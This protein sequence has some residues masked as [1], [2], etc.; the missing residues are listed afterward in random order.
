[1]KRLIACP[2]LLAHPP[3]KCRQQHRLFA[4]LTHRLD[5]GPGNNAGVAQMSQEQLC[6]EYLGK[7]LRTS[8]LSAS[9]PHLMI[10]KGVD[11]RLV[12]LRNGYILAARKK[13]EMFRRTHKTADSACRVVHFVQHASKCL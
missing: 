1:M 10:T 5:D 8:E 2:A 9:A 12:H 6:T 7:R 4:Y 11:Q 13:H 3:S